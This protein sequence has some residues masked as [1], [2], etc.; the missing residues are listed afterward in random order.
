MY[1]DIKYVVELIGKNTVNTMPENTFQAFLDHGVI[2][3]ALTGET[4][5]TENIIEGLNSFIIDINRV[6]KKLLDEGI[7]SFQKSFESL[8]NS[9]EMKTKKLCVKI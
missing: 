7:V 8:L 6:C 2:R 3:E 4:E 5:E 9:V 1:S